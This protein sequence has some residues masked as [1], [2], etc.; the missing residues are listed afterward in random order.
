MNFVLSSLTEPKYKAIYIT[1]HLHNNREI[2]ED[3]NY[4]P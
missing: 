4:E 1:D 3:V 2:E